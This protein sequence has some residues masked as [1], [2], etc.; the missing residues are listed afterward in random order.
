VRPYNNHQ[1]PNYNFHGSNRRLRLIWDEKGRSVEYP[2]R[3][4]SQ[5]RGFW[6]TTGPQKGTMLDLPYNQLTGT[7]QVMKAVGN[8]LVLT[9]CNSLPNSQMF[10]VVLTRK[11][12][13]LTRD[14]SQSTR[15]PWI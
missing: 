15:F 5:R 1:R 3:V 9:F 7:V 2:L 6:M 14:V 13:L 10:T 12:H 8:H 4:D 11:P